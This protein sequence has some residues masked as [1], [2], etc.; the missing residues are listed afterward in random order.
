MTQYLRFHKNVD[1]IHKT[2]FVR[3]LSP[4]PKLS[5][6]IK[7]T[8]L[9]IKASLLRGFILVNCKTPHIGGISLPAPPL[10]TLLGKGSKTSQNFQKSMVA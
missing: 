5:R 10:G 8:R 1:L 3:C 9:F 6:T 7:N 4:M 2:T